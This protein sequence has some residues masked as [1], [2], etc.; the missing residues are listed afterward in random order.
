[1]VRTT[2]RTIAHRGFA[3]TFPENTVAAALAA[4][5]TGADMIEVDVM[6]CADGE[7][8][9]FH[10]ERLDGVGGS[11]G[12][13]DGRG[14]VW[15][16]PCEEVREAS[17]LDTPETV[18]TLGEVLDALSPDVGVNVEL[19]NPGT[20]D[21]RAGEALSADALAERRAVWEPFVADVLS[22]VADAGHE[23]LFSSFCE[24]AIAA[25]SD[26]APDLATAAL[27]GDSI[28]DGLAI[29]RRYDCEAIHPPVSAIGAIP[30]F[31]GSPRPEDQ[32]SE[33]PD[34]LESASRLDCDVNV[35]TVRTWYQ[36]AKLR[37]AGVDGLIVDHPDLLAYRPGR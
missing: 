24:A 20:S 2:P 29:A 37:E 22:V 30:S 33:E 23:F 28:A 1:M 11:R 8:V 15:E 36:A 34:L 26:L 31:E 6:P 25:V 35:W 13:T 7:V 21:L 17:V 14:V 9:V 4:A 5:E 18:P 12:I 32:S 3:G 19:K 10:D 27:V 16:T